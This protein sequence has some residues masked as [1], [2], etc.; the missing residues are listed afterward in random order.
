MLANRKVPVA[1]DP[2]RVAQEPLLDLV[3]ALNG[4]RVFFW[5]MCYVTCWR[6]LK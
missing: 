3:A 2:L 4:L 5:H 6:I 1:L